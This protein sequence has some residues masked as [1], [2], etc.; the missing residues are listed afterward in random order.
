MKRRV[1][2][3]LGKD[4]VALRNDFTENKSAAL[5]EKAKILSYLGCFNPH[6]NYFLQLSNKINYKIVGD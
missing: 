5:T 2:D 6:R 4:T 3:R 1:P